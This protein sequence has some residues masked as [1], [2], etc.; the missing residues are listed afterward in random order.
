V[1]VQQVDV[2]EMIREIRGY[3]LLAGARGQAGCDVATLADLLLSV[4]RLM[5]ERTEIEELDLN[6]VRLYEHGL[7]ALD[8]RIVTRQARV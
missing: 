2:Q 5:V 4:S 7:M 6:P 1:P 8:A 3:P